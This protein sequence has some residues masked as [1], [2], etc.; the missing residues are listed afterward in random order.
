LRQGAPASR[1]PYFIIVDR[2][3]RDEGTS[4][5]YAA[6]SSFPK[7]ERD[8]VRR[9]ASAVKDGPRAMVGASSTTDAPFRETS[10]AIKAA[11]ADGVAI[12]GR[13]ALDGFRW[14]PGRR[15]PQP[16]SF[17]LR[18]L[19]ASEFNPRRTT[20]WR[21]VI[22]SQQQKR[23]QPA[24]T[25]PGGVCANGYDRCVRGGIRMGYSA[26]EAGAFCTRRCGGR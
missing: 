24:A 20:G 25:Q 15:I 14:A 2:A 1:P 18:P 5:H 4:Y 17:T 26:S 23:P 7:A 22:K 9:A 3:L 11:R 13:T 10:E 12:R 16:E 21:N 6:A 19:E 8:L